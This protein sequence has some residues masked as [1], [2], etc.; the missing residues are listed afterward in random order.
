MKAVNG[1]AFF[2]VLVVQGNTTYRVPLKQFKSPGPG[3][4]QHKG[5][6]YTEQEI[7]YMCELA[8]QTQTADLK[9]TDR[10]NGTRRKKEVIPKFLKDMLRVLPTQIIPAPEHPVPSGNYSL[11]PVQPNFHP[12]FV[13]FS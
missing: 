1:W 11:L 7:D 2:Y 5:M 13:H 9:A 3:F 4:T 12:T 10:E 8:C 6:Q